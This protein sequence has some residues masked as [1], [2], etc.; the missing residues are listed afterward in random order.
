[1]AVF[2]S[3]G[4]VALYTLGEM[5]PRV[6]SFLL[7]PVLT[8]YLS[9]SDYGISS[10]IATVASFLFVL[11]S[12]SVNTY[13]LRS[14]YKIN[15]LESKKRM[16]GNLYLF[17]NG[18]GLM[19][20][21]V[22]SM[23]FPFL[24]KAYNVQV[25]FYP[26][27]LLGLIINFF[28]VAAIIPLIYYRVNDN[29][30]G[31][32]LLSVGRTILQYIFVLFFV[33]FLNEG[34]FGSLMGRLL[35]CIPFGI[36][37]FLIIK[38]NGILKID[39]KQVKEALIFSLP[40]LPG[41]LSYLIITVFDR[42]ILER[43]VPLNELGL[44]AVASTLSLTLNVVVQGIYRSFEQK[45]FKEYGC[46]GYP[47]L[48]DKLYKIYIAALSIPGFCMVLFSKEL[49]FFFT[50]PQYY[51]SEKYIAYLVIAVIISGINTFFVTLLVADNKRKIITYTSFVAAVISFAVNLL[52]IKYYQVWG[53]CI[54]S[55]LSFLV[56]YVFY[57][58]RIALMNKYFLHQLSI[59]AIFVL[60]NNILPSEWPLLAEV[61]IKLLLLIAFA[62]YILK[63]FRIDIAGFYKM[64]LLPLINKKTR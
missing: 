14:Y 31:F 24:L 29:A 21:L 5:I 38:K 56:M 54:A 20:L 7:L 39:I 18:W 36:V 23:L 26:Y 15:N 1:M 61:G 46:E 11:T 53:A 50:S 58:N 9:T 30:R 2:K 10:Y 37:Y 40:L 42:V 51:A 3:A 12:L 45:I 28:D 52:L 64:N 43:Y 25:P 22:E 49:L 63:I 60:A 62:F 8:K 44:Y 41:A 17:L 35:G 34:L 47:V 16:L 4:N 19:M 13:A 27:F 32:V 48:T 55:I 59:A 6:L 57:S 33:V